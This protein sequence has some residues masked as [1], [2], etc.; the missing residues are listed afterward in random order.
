MTSIIRIFFLL[1]FSSIASIAQTFEGKITYLNTYKS[2]IPNVTDALFTEMMGTTQ[3]YNF[4]SGN[5]RSVSNGTFL[6]WQLYINKD[7]KLYTKFSN[8]PAIVWNDGAVNPDSVIKTELN[9]EVVD[10]LGYKCDELIFT[11]TSGVQKYYFNSKLKLDP[12]FFENHKFGNWYEYISRSKAV[13]LKIIVDNIQFS[14][15]SIATAVQ[16]QKI[17]DQLFTLPADAKLEKSPY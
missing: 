4:K 10:I 7:N 12:K 9:K 1:C 17:N 5:Y 2:K 8:S 3:E 11:C 15:E 6:Q 16:P 14:L 13:P